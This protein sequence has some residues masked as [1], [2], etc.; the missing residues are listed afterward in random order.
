MMRRVRISIHVLRVEDDGDTNASLAAYLDFNP[1]PPCGGRRATATVTPAAVEFQSTSSVWRTTVHAVSSA[2]APA[3][4]SIHVL[5]V[6]DDV[7]CAHKGRVQPNFNP[8]PPCGGRPATLAAAFMWMSFQ[9][10]SSVWRTTSGIPAETE[11]EDISIHV[12]RVEDDL[13]CVAGREF[14][15]KFQSTSSVWRTTG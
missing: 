4:I 14:C 7:Q 8:R 15:E 9:S 6:E 3:E 2:A 5:R 10:T 13:L 12:L 1:R 11:K